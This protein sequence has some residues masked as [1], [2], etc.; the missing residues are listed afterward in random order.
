MHVWAGISKRGATDIVLFQSN[1][2]ATR[3]TNILEASLLAFIKDYFPDGHRLFQ[4]NDPKHTS[5]WAQWFFK[6]K[7]LNWWPTPAESLDINPIENVWGAVKEA[8][9]STYKPRNL[10]QLEDAIKHYWGT[11]MTPE[12]CQTFIGHI[13]TVLPKVVEVKGQ[14][15]GY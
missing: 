1:M 3:Y 11:K 7:G 9:R 15:S 14:A 4:D 10:G 8:I 5:R 6:E 12:F 2:T 13:H